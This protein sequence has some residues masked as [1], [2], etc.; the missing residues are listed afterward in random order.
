MTAATDA[1]VIAISH[2]PRDASTTLFFGHLAERARALEVI[3][4][5]DRVL[6]RRIAGA[7]AIIL[8][9]GLFEFSGVVGAAHA[10]GVPLYY[11]L[12]D[13]FM[14]LRDEPGPWSRFVGRYSIG[15]VRRRLRA[16]SGVL[17]STPTLM[18]YF[19]AERLH[20]ELSLFPPI[21]W[22]YTLPD[23]PP[24]RE[25]RLAFFGGQH[26]HAMFSECLLP[27]IRRCATARP[28]TLMAAGVEGPI[29]PSPGLTVVE[30]SYD[31]SYVSGMRRLAATGV[32]V[33]VHPV[34]LDL[35]N[36]V[37]KIPHALISAGALG[38]VPVVSNRAPYRDLGNSGVALLCD[39]TADAWHAA[40]SQLTSPEQR[41]PITGRLAE[42]CAAQFGARVNQAVIEQIL[43]RHPRNDGGWDAWRTEVARAAVLLGRM[44]SASGRMVR[45]S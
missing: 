18:D 26:L 19:R 17:L 37:Y 8:V 23:T 25:L 42:Y 15:N 20:A 4:Y 31:P 38:A 40:L 45:A 6:S 33:L 21:E 41:T 2:D 39:D 34:P 24:S 16:F 7:R 28:V 5:G 43:S 36:T 44:A 13:N 35:R 14:V 32:D 10:L 30:Q 29:V 12:D 3:R 11:F 27:A 1:P 9:R 22:Q